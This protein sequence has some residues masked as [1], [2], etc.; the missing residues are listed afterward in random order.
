MQWSAIGAVNVVQL[1]LLLCACLSDTSGDDIGY[2]VSRLNPS[3]EQ[4]ADLAQPTHR[5]EIGF[6][7]RAYS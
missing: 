1:Y 2:Y 4:L 3:E 5:I 6:S 7:Q